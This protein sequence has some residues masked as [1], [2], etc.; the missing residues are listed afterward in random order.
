MEVLRDPRLIRLAVTRAK[1]TGELQALLM[2]AIKV[3]GKLQRAE[4]LRERQR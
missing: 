2:E 3:L 1:S 4:S